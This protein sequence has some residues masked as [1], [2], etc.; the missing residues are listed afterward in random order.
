VISAP[1]HV[2]GMAGASR[3]VFVPQAPSGLL[4]L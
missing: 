4:F 3:V 1:Q 2:N